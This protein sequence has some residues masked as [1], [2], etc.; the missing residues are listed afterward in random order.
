M[1]KVS[2]KKLSANDGR[3]MGSRSHRYR[4]RLNGSIAPA[5][6]KRAQLGADHAEQ[7]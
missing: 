1:G 5:Q 2:L 6:P 4:S 7:D 3:A